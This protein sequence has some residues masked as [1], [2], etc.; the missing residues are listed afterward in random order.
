MHEELIR[1]RRSREMVYSGPLGPHIDGFLTAVAAIG[2]T[3]S[4]LRDLANGAVQFSRYLASVGVIDAA[5]LCD[6]QRTEIAVVELLRQV[7]LQF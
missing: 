2:Y 4:S 1:S 3:S 7:P 6:Q 5:A